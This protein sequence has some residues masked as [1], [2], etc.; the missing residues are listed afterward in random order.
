M[1]RPRFNSNNKADSNELPK[2]SISKESL[3]KARYLLRYLRPYRAMFTIG[4][5]LLAG[6]SLL[7]LSFPMLMGWLIDAAM[8]TSNNAWLSSINQISIALLLILLVQAT[9]SFFRIYLFV[10]V[11]ERSLADLRKDSY[12]RIIRLPMDFF[13]RRR[14]GELNSRIAADLS[15]IQDT[16]TTTL[17]E[18]IRQLV[19]LIGGIALLA[20][21]SSKLTLLMLS[22][23]PVLVV[24]A[25]LFGKAIRR[26]AR[27]A[28]DELAASNTVVEESLQAIA[29]VKAYTNEWYESQRYAQ[30]IAGV[31][32]L[33]LK[34][35][36]YRGAFAS[37]IIF[38]LLGSIVVV[39]WYGSTLV[40]SGELTVG[41]LTSFIL[42][43][44]FVGA[45]MGSFAELYAQLQKALGAT[46]RVFEILNETTEAVDLLPIHPQRSVRGEVQFS[47]VSFRYPTRPEISVIDGVSFSV[48]AGEKLAVV[49]PS[50]AG[51]STLVS[52][53]QAF[54]QPDS[55]E[56]RIDDRPIS[57][58]ELSDYRANL[59]VVPQD[60][61]LFGGTIFE[62]ISYGKPGASR[63]EVE[64]AARKANA[65]EFISSFPEQLDTV[66]GERG[67][68]L[69]GGQRQRIAIARAVL[70]DPAI[71]ILDEATS[72][73]DS[74]S[75]RL[76]QDAL[77]LLMQNRTSIVIAHRLSTI[78]D[79][80]KIL[81]L[82]KGQIVEFGTHPEL[83]AK[84]NGLYRQ[85]KNLQTD[86]V[87]D[88]QP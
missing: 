73:L 86:L 74:E 87:D 9:I 66:V 39:I 28:Q 69:S 22:V 3:R 19:V 30:R 58:Y 82:D 42:Y 29:S 63:D 6:G 64:Q 34:G 50:G 65:W 61:V 55:G 37:F 16:L 53:L 2:A 85:L 68:K 26:I 77:N 38:C 33:A 32:K 52:L 79:A 5:V 70:R 71:L 81:V 49:G 44:T 36:I 24:L 12:S 47:E 21:T 17:A 75:E 10:Q 31:V 62:N 4:L 40:N 67:I 46:E 88:L 57:D 84:T 1:A 72:S 25:V 60:V 54:Y 15:Q 35:A 7:S 51:K 11:G 80:D 8:G 18:L 14:V 48:A 20:Y 76:V 56:I 59:A 45:A 27:E 41:K 13:A 78:R 83:M 43:S 23:F